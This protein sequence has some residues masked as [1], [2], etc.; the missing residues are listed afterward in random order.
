MIPE[1]PQRPTVGLM[2]TR[3]FIDDGQITDPSV[4]V[5]IP[6]VAKSDAMP[7]PVPELDPQGFRS[8]AYGL[9][10]WPPR[11]LHPLLDRVERKFAHSLKFVLPMMTAPPAMSRSTMNAFP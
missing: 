8:S 7:A 1:R 10:V 9:F 5:P 6:T 4:S 11:P 2:P 3:P